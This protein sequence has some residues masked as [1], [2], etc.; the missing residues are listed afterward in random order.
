MYES[1]EAL[2]DAIAVLKS[3]QERRQILAIIEKMREIGGRDTIMKLA[4]CM[5][6]EDYFKP[7]GAA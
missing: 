5:M 7:K 4:T 2:E 1:M 6:V 3:E